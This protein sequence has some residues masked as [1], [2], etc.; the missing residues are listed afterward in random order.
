MKQKGATNVVHCVEKSERE[1]H[2]PQ[3]HNALDRV[4]HHLRESGIG[5]ERKRAALITADIEAKLWEM[6]AIVPQ[7]LLNVF[8]YNGKNFCLRGIG[9]HQ[10]LRF[11]QIVHVYPKN[12]SG[13][14]YDRSK[15]KGVSIVGTNSPHSHV[16]ILTK[17]LEKIPIAE[18][19]P[20]STFYL[21][22]LPFTP[23]GS[24]AWYFRQP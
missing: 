1:K 16:S 12:H 2:Y 8:F 5:V 11:S 7:A 13:G 20:D 3:L 6:G 22:P 14:V 24:R 17:Y 4:L 21:N 15:G 18:I 19:T 10:N 23:T 9:E